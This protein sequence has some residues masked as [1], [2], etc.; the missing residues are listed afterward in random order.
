LTATETALPRWDLTNVFPSPTSPEYGAALQ[1]YRTDLDKLRA[2]Y[3]E[4]GIGLGTGAHPQTDADAIIE[5]TNTV[6]TQA[7]LLDN[8]LYCWT[9]TDSND[10]AAASAYGELQM[11]HAGYHALVPR[12]TSWLGTMQIDPERAGPVLGDHA[13][14]VRRAAVGAQHVMSAELEELA[15][16]MQAT[17]GAAWVRFRDESDAGLETTVVEDGVEKTISV[18]ELDS[19]LTSADREHRRTA[20]MAQDKARE[21]AAPEFASALNAIKGEALALAKRRNWES[22]LDWSLHISAIDR[23]V[24]QAMFTAVESVHADLH[25]FL[26]IKARLLGIADMAHYDVQA[27]ISADVPELTW[28]QCANITQRVLS[29]FSP[30]LARVVE[31]ALSQRWVDVE[32]REGKVGG[33]YCAGIPGH[34]SRILINFVPAFPTVQVLAHELGHAHHNDCLEG[35]TMLQKEL[36]MTLAETASMF[37][38]RLVEDAMLA[39]AVA[40]EQLA[41]LDQILGESV[42]LLLDLHA[43]F[44]FEEAIFELRKDRTISVAEFT[45]LMASKQR[46]AYGDGLAADGV[47]KWQWVQKPHYYDTGFHFYNYPYQFG[48]LFALGLLQVYRAEGD[49]FVDRYETLLSRA[50]MA[51]ARQLA[52]DF[53]ID[54]RDTAFWNG[55]VDV[56]RADI[57]RFT[58]LADQKSL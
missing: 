55:S 10:A 12:L 43:R 57:A 4:F 39:E 20:A 56:I 1:K 27:P 3:D 6:G 26:Q 40:D 44:H 46:V 28:E 30:R 11:V 49:R 52:N 53:G 19:W 48:F 7:D 2:M 42:G 5:A 36:P 24:L 58:A 23:D 32:P 51:S 41:A 47:H 38:Q 37:A 8:Y 54:I 17:G 16:A 50:G 13:Y 14:T 35:R 21:L 9:S 22:P 29:G 34:G 15:A 45:D 25:G 18:T 33:G 31:T